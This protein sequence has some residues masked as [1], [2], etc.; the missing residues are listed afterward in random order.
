MKSTIPAV[1]PLTTSIQYQI[2]SF[3]RNFLSRL[4]LRFRFSVQKIM[5]YLRITL[6]ETLFSFRGVQG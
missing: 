1:L 4:N 3:D 2:C 6:Q 5:L